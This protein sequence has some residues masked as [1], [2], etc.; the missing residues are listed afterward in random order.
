M[1]QSGRLAQVIETYMNKSTIEREFDRSNPYRGD[2]IKKLVMNKLADG[3]EI[4]TPSSPCYLGNFNSTTSEKEG[5]I[6]VNGSI[7]VKKGN[8]SVGWVDIDIHPAVDTHAGSKKTMIFITVEDWH[9]KAIL[10]SCISD[11]ARKAFETITSAGIRVPKTKVIPLLHDLDV[12]IDGIAR[13]DV[14]TDICIQMVS[15]DP[16]FFCRGY[17]TP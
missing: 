11:G 1:N 9:R 13:G 14:A 3:K 15:D 17:M 4:L 7:E 2:I 8:D 12:T 6:S 16:E 5:S 10:E